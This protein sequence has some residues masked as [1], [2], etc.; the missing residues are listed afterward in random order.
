MQMAHLASQRE[1]GPVKPWSTGQHM[2]AIA[3]GGG[4]EAPFVSCCCCCC[5]V[6]GLPLQSLNGSLP[7]H[8]CRRT[9]CQSN[10][11]IIEDPPLLASVT[12][13][14]PLHTTALSVT[15]VLIYAVS[16]ENA[17]ATWACIKLARMGLWIKMSSSTDEQTAT[18]QNPLQKTDKRSVA[19]CRPA[20]DPATI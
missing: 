17:N 18:A 5:I 16:N 20:R 14:L 7:K 2:P 4:A 19:G 15:A 13:S 8:L 9:P 11:R 1:Q 10:Q 12:Q 3:T 6:G